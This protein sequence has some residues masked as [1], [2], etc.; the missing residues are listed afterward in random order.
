M[1][2][3]PLGERSSQMIVQLCSTGASLTDGAGSVCETQKTP[4]QG[5]FP[6][7]MSELSDSV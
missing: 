4:P 7:A 2:G 3:L 5:L 6:E 1:G